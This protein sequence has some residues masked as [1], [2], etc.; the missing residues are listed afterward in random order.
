MI[1]LS[2]VALLTVTG[3]KK[4]D[5]GGHADMR[6]QQKITCV[7]NLKQIGLGFSGWCGDHKLKYPC[8]VSTNDGGALELVDLDKDGFDTNAFQYLKKMQG[9]DYLLTTPLILVCPQDHSKKAATNWTSLGPENIT[10]RFRAGTKVTPDSKE[11]LAV[12]PVDG[13]ILYCD[14]TVLDKDGKVP[15]SDAM[16]VRP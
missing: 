4:S 3:C 10:Y 11:V 1:Y 5:E 16:L 6:Y 12:C 2:A 14:G 9:A 8:N 7:N 13:N 15:K